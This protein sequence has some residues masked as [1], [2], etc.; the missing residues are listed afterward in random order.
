[1]VVNSLIME[2]N[3]GTNNS[4]VPSNKNILVKWDRKKTKEKNYECFGSSSDRD[5]DEDF[6]FE[7]NLALFDK[8][9]I[10]NKIN[11]SQPDLVCIL[12]Y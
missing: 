1:M 3:S 5:M 12:T 8:Q 2:P 7:K 11:A 9:A 4:K 6:D 10:W